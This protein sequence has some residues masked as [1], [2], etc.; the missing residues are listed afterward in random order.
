MLLA[1][2]VRSGLFDAPIT[3]SVWWLAAGGGRLS[4]PATVPVTVARPS[5]GAE[6]ARSAMVRLLPLTP[7]QVVGAWPDAETVT[8]TAPSSSLQSFAA[9]VASPV[10]LVSASHGC[11]SA[12]AP[13]RPPP[14]GR[15]LRVAR[16]KQPRRLELNDAGR[17]RVRRQPRQRERRR[18]V[19][20]RDRPEAVAGGVLHL[21]PVQRRARHRAERIGAARR[22]DVAGRR[23]PARQRDGRPDVDVAEPGGR[24]RG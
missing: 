18:L 14:L 22:E 17:Q 7:I 4:Q 5:A 9:K 20:D 10:E 15:P 3:A 23:Q 12:A 2:S 19:E 8:V 11:A 24:R 1:R 21:A 16:D 13:T 6:I